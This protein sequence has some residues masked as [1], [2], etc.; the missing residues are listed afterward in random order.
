MVTT[1]LYILLIVH[2]CIYTSCISNLYVCVNITNESLVFS[3][4]AWEK[5]V[6]L[7]IF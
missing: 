3:C 1:L 6:L 5:I 2:K 4:R 7:I